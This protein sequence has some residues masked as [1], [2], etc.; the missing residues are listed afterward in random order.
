[1]QRQ[2]RSVV[3]LLVPRSVMSCLLTLPLT[4]F[5]QGEGRV[6]YWSPDGALQAIVTPV[7]VAEAGFHE[8]AVEIRS[9]DGTFLYQRDFSSEDHEHGR[10]VAYAT[11]SP[12]SQFFT[13]STTSSGGHSTWHTYT[14]SYVRRPNQIYY[15][16]DFVG[17]SLS[18]VLFYFTKPAVFHSKRYNSRED[19]GVSGKPINVEVDLNSIKF[20]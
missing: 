4:I 11:W 19:K 8:H 14:F 12:D 5:A 18:E 1:M 15:L 3:S 13:F 10:C 6:I 20:G 9:K 16:D 7:H 17:G 2:R